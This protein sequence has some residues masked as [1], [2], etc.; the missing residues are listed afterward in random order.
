MIL[1]KNNNSFNSI[2]NTYIY[3]YLYINYQYLVKD[4]VN[5]IINNIKIPLEASPKCLNVSES[6]SKLVNKS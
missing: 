1:K 5:P 2:L 4:C 3:I 6:I